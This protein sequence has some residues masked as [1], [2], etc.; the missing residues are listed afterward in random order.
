MSAVAHAHEIADVPRA[1]G[2]VTPGVTVQIVD[3]SGT[4]LPPGKEG[5]VRVN[6]EYAVGSYFGNPEESGKV[7]REGWF[8]PGDLGT[9]S[10]QGLLTITGREHAVLNLGGDKISPETIELVL[11]QFEG[12]AEAAAVSV[13]NEYGNNEICALLVCREQPD[14]R[15]L[16]SHCEANIPRTFVPSRYF[17]VDRLPHN[18][19][20]KLDRRQLQ[21][22][23]NKTIERQ[24]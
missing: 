5:Y 2:F 15:M 10:P 7:F 11:A 6:S 4:I 17:F 18:E 21:A 23:V 9:L 16:R 20:G 3:A 13:P 8:Y 19:M 1:V 14:E 12:V 22:L 24:H